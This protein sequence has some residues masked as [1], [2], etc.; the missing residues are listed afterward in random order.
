M[1]AIINLIKNFISLIKNP[2]VF[3]G[4]ITVFIIFLPGLTKKH[5]L[6]EK[7]AF[8]EKE[9]KRLYRENKELLNEIERLKRDPNYQEK[10]VREKLGYVKE[11]EMVLRLEPKEEKAR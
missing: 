3:I 2:Y 1:R 11:G 8:L 7:R 4:A 6:M 9:S 5:D 10:M